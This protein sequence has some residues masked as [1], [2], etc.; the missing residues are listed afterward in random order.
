M[1]VNLDDIIVVLNDWDNFK[2]PLIV[3]GLVLMGVAESIRAL[4]SMG[5]DAN[6][7][8]GAIELALLCTDKYEQELKDHEAL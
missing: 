8:E 6:E 7:I 1:D 4:E 2:A 3:K 5:Q